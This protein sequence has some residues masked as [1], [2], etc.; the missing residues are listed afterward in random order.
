VG[1][2]GEGG[3]GV[4]G[5]G[6]VIVGGVANG[7][8]VDNGVGGGGNDSEW[9]RWGV[10]VAGRCCHSREN[11][12]TPMSAIFVCRRC[13][14]RCCCCWCDECRGFCFWSQVFNTIHDSHVQPCTSSKNDGCLDLSSCPTHSQK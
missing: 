14:N 2:E 4:G 1:T 6:R 12:I 7:G 11:V 8:G 10:V 13:H 9:W 5:D 3:S